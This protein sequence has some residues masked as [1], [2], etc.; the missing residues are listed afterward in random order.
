ME[1]KKRVLGAEHPDTLTS[2][3]NLA[4]TWKSQGRVHEALALME[5]CVQFRRQ[6]LGPHH[7]DTTTSL[8]AL[9]E[10]QRESLALGLTSDP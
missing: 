9:N 7:P 10:W 6:T 1:T 2:M 5:E 3:N 8:V 4:C